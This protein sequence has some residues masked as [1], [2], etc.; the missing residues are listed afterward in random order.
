MWQLSETQTV[1]NDSG[2]V[3][4]TN[5]RLVW[6]LFCLY[7]HS[8]FILKLYF[9]LYLIQTIFIFALFLNH[10]DTFNIQ[11]ANFWD[12]VVSLHRERLVLRE[13]VDLRD[14][15]EP[16]VSLVTQDLL[17]PLELLWVDAGLFC[18]HCF[19]HGQLFFTWQGKIETL[20]AIQC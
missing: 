11:A 12:I 7:L 14:P 15:R 18:R 13:A 6:W 4:W 16:V 1:W 2:Y 5:L 20:N 8:L 19:T 3:Q 10:W 17:D 9:T